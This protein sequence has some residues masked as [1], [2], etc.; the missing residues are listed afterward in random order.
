MDMDNNGEAG[1]KL[2]LEGI[3]TAVVG[4]NSLEG[5]KNANVTWG[6]LSA[7]LQ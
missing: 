6:W 7:T 4:G 5:D 1:A 3:A 2:E